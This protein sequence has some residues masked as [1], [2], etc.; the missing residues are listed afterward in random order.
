[1]KKPAPPSARELLERGALELERAGVTEGQWEAERLFRHAVGWS[2]EQLLA[3][4][5][6]PIHAEASGL[7]FQLLERRRGR[8]PLQYVIGVQEFWGMELRVTPAVFIPRA[9]TEGIVE[10]VLTRYRGRP[11]AIVDVGCG[12]G[13]IAMAIASELPEARVYATEISLAAL[14]VARENANRNRLGD[15]I[16]FLQGDL[17]EP[18]SGRGLDGTFDA[19]VS[20]PPYITDAEMETLAPEIRWYEPRLALAGGEDGLD[21]LRRL[22]PQ[23]EAL[24]RPDG[25]LFLEIGKDMEPRLKAFLSETGLVW[26]ETIADLQGLPRVLI[27]G[28]GVRRP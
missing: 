13:C 10:Q 16:Q 11:A 27:A 1:M 24:L 4:P 14:A 17:L 7:F 19:V 18:L 15:R 5:D 21:V 9:E 23:A 12:S 6:Q 26:E 25:R 22:L 2:R 28:M 20:N 8:E 3:H